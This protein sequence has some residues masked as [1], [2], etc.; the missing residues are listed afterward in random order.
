LLPLIDRKFSIEDF[1]TILGDWSL[2]DE[3]NKLKNDY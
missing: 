2:E 1:N 3:L